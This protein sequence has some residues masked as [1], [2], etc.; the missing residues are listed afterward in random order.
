M[1]RGRAVSLDKVV[2]VWGC[3]VCAACVH[4]CVQIDGADNAVGAISFKVANRA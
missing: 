3:A 2:I 1:W 4:L